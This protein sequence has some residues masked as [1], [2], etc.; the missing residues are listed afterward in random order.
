MPN[1]HGYKLVNG[2][3]MISCADLPCKGLFIDRI[4]HF[5]ASWQVMT[6]RAVVKGSLANRSMVFVRS[7]PG[8]RE[9]GINF[10]RKTCPSYTGRAVCYLGLF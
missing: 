6:L 7:G 8:F 3:P 10:V 4:N 5:N 9:Y 2:I 1:F